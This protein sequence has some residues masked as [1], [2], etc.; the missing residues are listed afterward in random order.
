M[1]KTITKLVL[2]RETLKLLIDSELARVAGGH[3]TNCQTRQVSGCPAAPEVDVDSP[4][5]K[6]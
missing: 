6:D 5:R 2:R 4:P 1:K 3:D